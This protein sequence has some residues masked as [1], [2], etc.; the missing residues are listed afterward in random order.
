MSKTTLCACNQLFIFRK[1][2][3]VG[4]P[5][6]RKMPLEIKIRWGSMMRMLRVA[7]AQVCERRIESFMIIYC[8]GRTFV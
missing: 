8:V 4:C 7:S 3:E 6:K 5:D 2:N 1:L